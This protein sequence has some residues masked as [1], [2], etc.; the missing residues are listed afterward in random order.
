MYSLVPLQSALETASTIQPTQFV[1]YLGRFLAF[2]STLFIAVYL[3][4]TIVNKLRQREQ[5]LE[6]SNKLLE[7]QDKLKSK[8]VMI[9]SHDIQ[10]S[11]AASDSCLQT[12]LLG[13]TGKI[14]EKSRDM[15]QRAATRTQQ[16]LRFARDLLDVSKMRIQSDVPK[17]KV[18]LV[19]VIEKEIDLFR[20]QGEERGIILQF[21]NLAGQVMLQANVTS[22]QQLFNNILSNALRYSPDGGEIS[23]ILESAANRRAVEIRVADSG[24]GIAPESL[25]HIFNDFYRA[26]NAREFTENG[27]GLGLSIVKRIVELHDGEIRVESELNRGTTFIFTLATEPSCPIENTD[28]HELPNRHVEN[29]L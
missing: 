5:E 24:I 9:V 10:A 21:D 13:F 25:P 27:T 3:T 6:V 20:R 7:E 2:S 14:G 19:E 8:Y 4:T 29:P 12:V 18:D 28:T 1:S 26:G 15:I 11:L 23:V 17:Q 16:L 22:L